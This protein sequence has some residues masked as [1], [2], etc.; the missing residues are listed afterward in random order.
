MQHILIPKYPLF[1]V[2]KQCP[3]PTFMC[4]ICMLQ[5]YEKFLH[6]L[7]E[8]KQK[9]KLRKLEAEIV[10]KMAERADYQAYYYKPLVNKYLRIN[11][12]TGEELIERMGDDVKE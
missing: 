9:I 5:E 7:D 4:T 8:E 3:T 11:K 1:R 2:L 10:K 6:F 12:K